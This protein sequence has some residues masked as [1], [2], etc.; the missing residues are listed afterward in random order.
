MVDYLNSCDDIP[1]ILTGD[2]N[3]RNESMAV[4]IIKEKMIQ[5][6]EIFRNTLCYSTHPL[7]QKEPQN[8]GYG[9]DHIFTR[10]IRVSGCKIKDVEV[11]DHLPLVLDFC[12]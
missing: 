1:T 4:K 10:N 11:S 8:P 12:L 5:H 3:I 2:L 9:I 6:S 7:F